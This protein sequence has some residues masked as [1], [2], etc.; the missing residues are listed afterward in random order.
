MQSTFFESLMLADAER[1]HSQTLAWILNLN[2]S[3]FPKQEKSFL[4]KNIFNLSQDLI[5]ED[6]YFIGTEINSLDIVI[7]TDNTTMVIE[8]KLKSSEHSFQSDKYLNALPNNLKSKEENTYFAFLSL[9]AESPKNPRWI[10]VSFENLLKSLQCIKW[11][12]EDRSYVFIEE[13][14][15]TLENLVGVFNHFMQNHKEYETVFLD[16][17]KKKNEKDPEDEKY[18]N[19]SKKDYIRRNQLETIFQKAF[20]KKVVS[21]LDLEDYHISETHGVALLQVNRKKITIVNKTFNLGFQFQGNT[22]KINFSSEEYEKSKATQI[23]KEMITAFESVFKNQNDFTRFNKPKT[24]AYMSVSKKLNKQLF[25]YNM[26]ELK[27][28]IK[29]ILENLNILL[30]EFES[31]LQEL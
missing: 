5:I 30:P 6:Y 13:Y 28:F 4:F 22:M 18:K 8:N 7:R 1:I 23:T 29:A 2:E 11:N 16:G 3:I 17:H 20:I 14:I 27:A 9:T 26:E 19:Y 10:S 31:K 25:E 24:K 12:K 21:D 15:K